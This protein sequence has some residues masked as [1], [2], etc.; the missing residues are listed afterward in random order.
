MNIIEYD[1][2]N[3]EYIVDYDKFETTEEVTLKLTKLIERSNL[4]LTYFNRLIHL[5][6][7]LNDLIDFVRKLR[8]MF[9]SKGVSL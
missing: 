2:E 5:Y 7:V 6:A 4:R 3:E 1:T 8:V 9:R